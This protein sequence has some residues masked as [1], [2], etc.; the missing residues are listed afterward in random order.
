MG[1]TLAP[2][3]PQL[4]EGFGIAENIS[5]VVVTEVVPGSPAAERG[6]GTGDV[7]QQAGQKPVSQ[8]DEVR[9]TMD[10]ARR[11]GRKSILLLV[12][13]QSDLRFVPLPLESGG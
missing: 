8:P 4:R 9:S 10:E 13:R 1:L 3:S 6:I 5:G 2:M 12:N 11:S 7:I